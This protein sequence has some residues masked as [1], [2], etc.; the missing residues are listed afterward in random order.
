[1][2][3][4]IAA[5]HAPVAPLSSP[6][7]RLARRTRAL[8]LAVG[9]VARRPRFG[10]K[11][12]PHVADQPFGRVRHRGGG[13]RFTAA[14]PPVDARVVGQR[15]GARDALAGGR[16]GTRGICAFCATSGPRRC[17]G[18]AAPADAVIAE[19]KLD[20]PH[21]RLLPPAVVG[22][23]LVGELVQPEAEADSLPGVEPH[24]PPRAREAPGARREVGG[25][26][27]GEGDATRVQWLRPQ[28]G[29]ACCRWEHIDVGH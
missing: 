8:G 6:A 13:Q 2:V 20:Q 11:H 18:V 16:S 15:E 24:V 27:A 23:L 26:E 17:N 19:H 25:V 3:T 4:F 12:A 28:R 7:R 21:Q 5:V 22:Q 10:A 14:A 9:Q 29:L 1:M